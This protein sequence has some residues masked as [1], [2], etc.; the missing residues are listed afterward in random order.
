MT[1]AAAVA[2]AALLTYSVC[3]KQDVKDP[4]ENVPFLQSEHTVSL[5]IVPAETTTTTST[6][7]TIKW[8]AE[9]LMIFFQGSVMC[10]KTHESAA[11]FKTVTSIS[12]SHL[13]LHVASLLQSFCSG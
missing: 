9:V 13:N 7:V 11:S 4:F 2:R 3:G 12:G 5:F 10:L 1:A 8:C 6:T